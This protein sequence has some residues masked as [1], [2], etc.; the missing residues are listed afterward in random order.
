VFQANVA[1]LLLQR[2]TRFR[3]PWPSLTQLR[4]KHRLVE[5]F[6]VHVKHSSDMQ[7]AAYHNGGRHCLS[8]CLAG[9]SLFLV[10]ENV[11]D[12]R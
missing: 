12:C 5:K 6:A 3:C 7:R 11:T 2:N 9:G 10:R 4:E 1:L 8:D